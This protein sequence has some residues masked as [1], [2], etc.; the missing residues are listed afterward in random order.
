MGIK[1]L[2]RYLLNHCTEKSIHKNH[3]KNFANKTVV[4]DTSIYLYKF[5]ADEALLENM[6]LFI[7]LFLY[8]KITPIFIFDGKPPEEK[9]ALLFQRYYEKKEA[10]EKYNA[11]KEE[12]ESVYST[13]E[14]EKRLAELDILKR[15]FVRITDQDIQITKEL[16][17]AYGIQYY[18]APQEAD[19]LCGLFMKEKKADAC[20]SDD[21]DMFLYGCPFVLRNLSLSNHTV[22]QYDMNSILQDLNM[23]ITTFRE[24]MVLSG[25]DYDM[26]QTTN[27]Y[28]TMKLYSSYKDQS[29][30]V[31]FYDWLIENTKY[32][33]NYDLLVSIGKIFMLESIDLSDEMSRIFQKN[34]EYV[35]KK[36]NVIRIKSILEKDGFVFL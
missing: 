17:D 35:K 9:R 11:I 32:I 36:K 6:Y 26:N 29:A 33:C 34:G 23:S 21:M 19:Q 24:L 3:L 20:M 10:E 2:N 27:L 1:H 30:S 15:Q 25:T 28:Q 8:Y 7:S 14:K 13:E 4:I 22:M 18:D 12:I 16:L 31:S 5:V